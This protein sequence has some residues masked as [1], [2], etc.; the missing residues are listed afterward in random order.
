VCPGPS[1][2]RL[3]RRGQGRRPTDAHPPPG[4]PSRE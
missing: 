2:R 1:R 4:S 3:V